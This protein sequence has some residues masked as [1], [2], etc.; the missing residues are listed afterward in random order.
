MKPPHGVQRSARHLHRSSGSRAPRRRPEFYREG[1]F[2][3]A[4]PTTSFGTLTAPTSRRGTSGTGRASGPPTDRRRAAASSASSYH[5]ADGE[6]LSPRM[7]IV[8]DVD[9][10]EDWMAAQRAKLAEAEREHYE[11]WEQD[12]RNAW[13]RGQSFYQPVIPVI[14]RDNSKTPRGALR[15]PAEV[16]DRSRVRSSRVTCFGGMLQAI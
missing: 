13:E 1:G 2:P 16:S 3:P 9:D 5:V 10:P 14:V 4:P 12:A 11:P 7:A 15:S 6:R 8:R